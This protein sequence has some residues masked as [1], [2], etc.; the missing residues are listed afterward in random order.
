[1]NKRKLRRAKQIKKRRNHKDDMIMSIKALKTAEAAV[2]GEATIDCIGNFVFFST[3]TGEAW[4]LDHRHN[5]A[6]RLADKKKIL[7]YK[8]IESKE[9]FQVEWK[10]RYK[11]EDDIFIA[12]RNQN[13][14]VFTHYPI[15]A[16][17]GLVRMITK[18]SGA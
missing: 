7:P 2:A 4:M 16:I 12:T 9:R 8:I 18:N 11:I 17:E 13:E 1:M 6:L 14:D 10:E 5:Y 3:A 15:D